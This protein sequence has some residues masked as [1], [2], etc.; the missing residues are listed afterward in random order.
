M[1]ENK[2]QHYVPKVYLRAFSTVAG[3]AAINLLNVDR[4]QPIQNAPIKGQCARNYLYGRDGELEKAL[5]GPEGLYGRLAAKAIA[6]PSDLSDAE[7]NELRNLM[8]LQTFR[9]YGYLEK[10]IAM[11]NQHDADLLSAADGKRD[12]VE[13]LDMTIPMAVD[14]ALEHFMEMRWHIADLETVILVNNSRVDFLTSDDPAIHINR[15][16]VQRR[17]IGGYGMGSS[18]CILLMPIAPRLLLMAFDPYIYKADGP[19]GSLV[20]CREDQDVADLNALQLLHARHNVYFARWES[21][22]KVQAD[23]AK[24]KDGRP[25]TWHT[26]KYFRPAKQTPRGTQ[27]V[28]ID[29]P[30]GGEEVVGTISMFSQVHVTPNRWPRFLR[31][32][33]KPSFVDTGT[34]QGVVRPGHPSLKRVMRRDR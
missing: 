30:A 4:N 2:L 26:F 28:A 19:T 3:G 29:R 13:L 33:L 14:M 18:G 5:Q 23:F 24:A 32:R 6:N 16:H 27:Y 34:G 8:L 9:S 20:I 15:F 7:L 22:E 25:N 17:L 10:Q 12:Q 31:Y 21:A 11:S 1:P